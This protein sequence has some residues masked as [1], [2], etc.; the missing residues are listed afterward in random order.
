MSK[1][2][3]YSPPD[4]ALQPPPQQSLK[5]KL[6]IYKKQKKVQELSVA[7][8]MTK[9]GR[10]YLL[11]GRNSQMSDIILEH[12]SISRRHAVFL[13]NEEGCY[14]IMDLDS[15]HGTELN[16]KGLPGSE[17]TQLRGGDKICFGGSS[18][19]YIVHGAP[20]RAAEGM[21]ASEPSEMDEEYSGKRDWPAEAGSGHKESDGANESKTAAVEEPPSLADSLGFASFGAKRR[22]KDDLQSIHSETK[23]N[24]SNSTET[25]EGA[26]NNMEEE[27]GARAARRAEIERMAAEMQAAP[28]VFTAPP[29]APAPLE[30]DDPALEE[31]EKDTGPTVEDVTDTYQIPVS[32]EVVLK[33][34]SKPVVALSIDPAGSRLVTGSMDCVVK[35]FDFGGMDKTHRSFREVTPEEG[36]LLVALSYSCT[37]DKFIAATVSAQ[38]KVYD[39]DGHELIQFVKGDPYITDMTNTKG[40]TAAVTHAEFHPFNK[41]TVITSSNDGT[42]RVWDLNGQ[43]IF[44]GALICKQVIKLRNQRNLRLGA[45]TC[46]YSTEGGSNIVAGGADGSLHLYDSKVSKFS[47]AKAI[48]RNAHSTNE[49]ASVQFSSDSRQFASRGNDDSVKLWDIRKFKDPLKVFSGISTLYSSSNTAFSPD[50]RVLCA[51]TSVKKGEGVGMVKFYETATSNTEPVVQIGVAQG[52]GIIRICWPAKINHLLCS[53]SSGVTRVLYD[54]KYSVRGA[55]MSVKRQPRKYKL[56]DFVPDY[57]GEVLNPNALPMYRQ[58]EKEKWSQK[59]MDPLRSKRPEL[60]TTNKGTGGRVASR[61]GF[62]EFIMRGK[63]K[64]DSIKEQ[65]S[66]AVLLKYADAAEKDKEMLGQAYAS[67]QPQNLLADKTLEEEELAFIEEQKKILSETV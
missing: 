37:G 2:K 55:L 11:F 21:Q 23:R 60:P 28:A 16:G 22:R 45:T 57:V 63:A 6:A 48:V 13:A 38:P 10:G 18:R 51:G 50:G 1:S 25:G 26:N 58:K 31:E 53:T 40:H 43:T 59:R 35:V 3:P 39:R 65:D 54:P 4:W 20:S 44:T 62:T 49:V 47:R 36:N 42:V 64:A 34:H 67:T 66:R 33:G 29:D 12:P 8:E 30:D 41:D 52:A 56:E 32:H 24:E 61:F 7:K 17:P 27:D 15:A 14:F 46:C 19:R 9:Q 5:F